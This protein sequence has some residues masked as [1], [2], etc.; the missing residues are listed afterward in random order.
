MSA[1]QSPLTYEGILELFWETREQMKKTDLKFEEVARQMK[2][3]DK[4]ISALGS[5]IGEIVESMVKGN[6]VDKFQAFDYT[7]TKS[8]RNVKFGNKNLPC[9]EIDLFLENGEYVML[10][11]IKTD[12]SVSDVDRHLEKIGVI[13][14]YMDVR[15][16]A[17]K[18]VG[19]VAGGVVTGKVLD[20]AQRE[21]L[22]VIVQSGDA[23]E[24]ANLPKDFSAREW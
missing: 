3:T 9:G 14:E 19:A 11:E 22:Y 5:R 10:V 24:I 1:Q 21:G 17:R 20:Y 13:R 8:S 6:V 7:V 18:I 12:L 23:I 15:D 4:K 2:R 16:D